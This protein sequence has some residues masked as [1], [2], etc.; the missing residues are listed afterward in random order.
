MPS[1][2]GNTISDTNKSLYIVEIGGNRDRIEIQFTPKEIS[3][4]SQANN[5]KIEV[6]GRNNPL[7]H[8][9]GGQDTLKFQLDFYADDEDREE[10]VKKVRWLQAL[11]YNNGRRNRKKNVLIVWGDLF[12][13]PFYVWTVDSVDVKY[14][15]FRSD[16]KY[17]PV[18]AYV[19][20]QFSLDPPENITI[21]DIR[22]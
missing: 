13:D 1:I 16:K 20:I 5:Q 6:I 14:S 22:K 11:R 18:Q 4:N 19:D 10:V 9:T 17:N 7:Y 8:Y 21:N 3:F 15:D 12:N 2:E